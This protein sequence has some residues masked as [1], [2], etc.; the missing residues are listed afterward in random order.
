LISWVSIFVYFIPNY[1][2]LIINFIFIT[3]KL[4]TVDKEEKR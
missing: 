1:A 3:F 2:I 4:F